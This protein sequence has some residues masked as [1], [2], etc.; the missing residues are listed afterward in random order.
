MRFDVICIY[1]LAM[2]GVINVLYDTGCWIYDRIQDM[3]KG[4]LEQEYEKAKD[5]LSRWGA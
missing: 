4:K 5:W 1:I 2:I 3:R